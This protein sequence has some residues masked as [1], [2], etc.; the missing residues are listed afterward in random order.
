MSSLFD[1]AFWTDLIDKFVRS[2]RSSPA[3]FMALQAVQVVLPFIPGDVT[4]FLGGYLFGTIWGFLYSTVGLTLGSYV[5]FRLARR[6]GQPL[7][8]RLIKPRLLRKFRF[9]RTRKGLLVSGLCFLIPGFPKD[10]LCYL[11][12]LGAMEM[13]AFL[14]IS[15]LGRLPGTLLLSLQGSTLRLHA[16]QELILLALISLGSFMLAYRF[17]KPIFLWVR[18]RRRL[19]T[20]E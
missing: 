19:S 9:L 12:G 3:S 8:V 4:G 15:S 18:K 20:N 10:A 16:Y 11:L 2:Q 13:E 6:Y 17:H 14:L 5:A 7:V 1:Q